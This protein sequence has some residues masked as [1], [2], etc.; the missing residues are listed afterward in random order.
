VSLWSLTLGEVLEERARSSV[1][2]LAAVCGDVRLTYGELDARV[3]GVA[4]ALHA[5]GIGAGSRVLWLGQNCHRALEALLACARL[6]AVCCPANWRQ[7][8]NELSLT[9]QDFRA[10][11][12]LW[13]DAGIE[14]LVADVRDASGS[15]GRWVE[16]GGD[17][18]AYE[19][20]AGSEMPA[21]DLGGDPALPVLGVYT[22]AFE[23]RPHCAL[24]NHTAIISQN[25]VVAAAHEIDRSTVYL[26]CGPMF[27]VG[28]LMSTL[29]TFQVGGRNIFMPKADAEQICRLVE[30]ERVTRAFIVEPTRQQIVDLVAEHPFDLSSLLGWPGT[31]QWGAVVRRDPSPWGTW[32]GG[33]GQTETM[34]HVSF[35]YVAAP[36]KGEHGRPTPVMEVRVVDDELAD[37]PVGE[38][39]EIVVRGPT[40]MNGYHDRPDENER[41]QQGG[42][43]RTG[44]LGRR[45][46]DGSLT[47]VGPQARM[48][49]SGVENI[50]PAEI[51]SCIRAHPDVADCAVI[52]VPDPVWVQS[53]KAVVVCRQGAALSADDV[54]EHCRRHIASYKKPKAVDFTD[55]LPRTGGQVDYDELDRR[56]GGGGYPGGATRALPG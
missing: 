56:F 7:T 6:G 10:D 55:V 2:E 19:Q 40:V 53:V 50:Y 31:P 9:L 46:T 43:H 34:G 8:A 44:D 39:G 1:D 4:G 15:T 47:F 12:V 49:K 26:N 23:G 25:L 24:L 54:I 37:L 45:E 16:A 42:W 22:A 20:M 28:T 3:N 29:A 52:G 18:S 11:V 13:Q 51:E 21:P 5:L 14:E 32:V 35:R 38:V 33:Y 30:R 36:S 17:R 41:R 27:H 48:L